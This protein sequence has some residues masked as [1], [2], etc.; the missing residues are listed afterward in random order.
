MT[1]SGAQPVGPTNIF[2]KAYA[3]PL[4]YATI[5]VWG[6]LLYGVSLR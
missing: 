5:A 4:L 3:R 6:A 1:S 2:S